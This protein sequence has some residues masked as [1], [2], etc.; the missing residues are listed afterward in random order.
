MPPTFKPLLPGN[1]VSGANPLSKSGNPDHKGHFKPIGVSGENTPPAVK[2]APPTTQ[3]A[4]GVQ[5]TPV[6]PQPQAAAAS[7]PANAPGSRVPKA[8]TVITRLI[9]D[10]HRITHIEVQCACGELITLACGYDADESMTESGR[11]TLQVP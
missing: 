11:E 9:R 10:G 1:S 5:L 6:Q 7:L 8:S 3:F 4:P 2:A